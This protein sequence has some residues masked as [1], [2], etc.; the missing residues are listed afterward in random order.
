MHTVAGAA[1]PF[2][3]Q[4]HNHNIPVNNLHID[5]LQDEFC[6]RTDEKNL[7]LMVKHQGLKGNF[8]QT[9]V[10]LYTQMGPLLTPT[11]T[12]AGIHHTLVRKLACTDRALYNNHL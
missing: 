2:P 10:P 5:L 3:V 4:L 12:K 7:I 11:L 1:K 9:S 8:T 6:C